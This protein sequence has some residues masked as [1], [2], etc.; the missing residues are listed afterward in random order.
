MIARRIVIRLPLLTALV[1]LGAWPAMPTYADAAPVAGERQQ[2]QSAAE[3]AEAERHARMGHGVAEAVEGLEVRKVLRAPQD[4]VGNVAYDP[5]SRR[6]LLVSFGPPANTKGPSTI[7][8][9][10]AES[11]EV[12]ERAKLPF[13]GEFGGGAIVGDVLY[14]VVPYQSTLYKV[15]LRKGTFGQVLSSVKLPT[16]NDLKLDNDVYR[17]PFIAFTGA[18]ALPDGTL[19][20]Y[21]SDLGELMTIDKDTG[22][23]RGRVRTSKG[24]AGLASVPYGDGRSLL[25]ASFD[26]IDSAFRQEQRRYMFRSAHG[27]LPLETVR[28][29]GNYGNP[30][31]KTVTW[32]LLD[33]ET[34]E[35]L[36]VAATETTRLLAGSVAVVSREDAPGTRYGRLTVWTTGEEGV[37]SVGWTPR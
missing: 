13:L 19:V 24:L 15:D 20:L 37:L 30:G 8:D 23:L 11:G 22:A 29:E 27:I 12:L 34:G 1:L 6:M 17:F 33:P 25:L 4:F 21:A 36:S 18:S 10:D 32:V 9:I 3:A 2:A 26:P 16:L 5:A 35:V 14:Q 31:Q 7:Y 28:A